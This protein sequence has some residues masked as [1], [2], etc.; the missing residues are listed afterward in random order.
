[1]QNSKYLTKRT[2]LH[3]AEFSVWFSI[4]KSAVYLLTFMRT[5]FGLGGGSG[6]ST[7]SWI[8]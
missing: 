6:D 1:M 8:S 3:Y 4:I 5:G 2:K 7:I